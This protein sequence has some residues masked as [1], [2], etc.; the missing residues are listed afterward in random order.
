MITSSLLMLAFMQAGCQAWFDQ[1][2]APPGRVPDFAKGMSKAE[3]EAAS[4]LRKLRRRSRRATGVETTVTVIPLKGIKPKT[5]ARALKKLYRDRPGFVVAALPEVGCVIVRADAKTNAEVISLLMTVTPLDAKD[6]KP[7]K[8]SG[9]KWPDRS[10]AGG[11]AAEPD[12][13]LSKGAS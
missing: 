12:S 9:S 10:K 3:V 8:G 11:V 2:G 4:A 5:A 13:T 7:T 6:R 1:P